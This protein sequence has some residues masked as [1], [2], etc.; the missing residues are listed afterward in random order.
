MAFLGGF[1]GVGIGKVIWGG[2]GHNLFNPALVGRAFLLA[3]FPIAMTTW[4]P[5]TP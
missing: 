3:T 4:V 2:L 5:A 1:V